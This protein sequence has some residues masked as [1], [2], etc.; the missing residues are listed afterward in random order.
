MSSKIIYH[1]NHTGFDETYQRFL[2]LSLAFLPDRA[3]QCKGNKRC[4]YSTESTTSFP[5]ASVCVVTV[6]VSY[7]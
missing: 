3:L 4:I 6:K 2:P 1:K 5:S 7:V